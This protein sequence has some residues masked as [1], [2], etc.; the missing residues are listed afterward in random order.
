MKNHILSAPCF[1]PQG[2]DELCRVCADPE[3][4]IPYGSNTELWQ[5]VLQYYPALAKHKTQPN[6]KKLHWKIARQLEK[7]TSQDQKPIDQSAHLEK[8]TIVGTKYGAQFSHSCPICSKSMSYR[9]SVNHHYK[10]G[11]CLKEWNDKAC[12]F[13]NDKECKVYSRIIIYF[14]QVLEWRTRTRGCTST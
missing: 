13:C 9:G 11:P 1:V 6:T 8:K 2:G 7:G 12:P 3:C 10:H 4:R 5:H 14:L